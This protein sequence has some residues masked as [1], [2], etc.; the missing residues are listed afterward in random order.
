MDDFGP[1]KSGVVDQQIRLHD[2]LTF[3]AEP[4][5]IFCPLQKH[6]GFGKRFGQVDFLFLA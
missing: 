3:V 4:L 6:V 1:F 2:L 5:R